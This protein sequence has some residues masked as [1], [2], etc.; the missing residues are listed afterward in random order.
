MEEKCESDKAE[1]SEAHQK[2][3]HCVTEH[4][5]NNTRNNEDRL[6]SAS[7]ETRRLSAPSSALISMKPLRSQNETL[8]K[9]WTAWG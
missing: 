2:K 6:G 3:F 9:R 8:L 7:D 1:Y 5:V 4:A